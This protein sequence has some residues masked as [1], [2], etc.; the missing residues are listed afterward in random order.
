M[1]LSKK[2]VYCFWGIEYIRDW[3]RWWYYCC[4]L[5]CCT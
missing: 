3:R 4:S 1:Q 2:V 5:H